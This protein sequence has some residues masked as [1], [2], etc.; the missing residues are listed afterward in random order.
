MP[1][2]HDT[3]CPLVSSCGDHRS[4]RR[5]VHRPFLVGRPACRCT[6]C[7]GAAA[8]GA[9]SAGPGRRGGRWPGSGGASGP[10]RQC[11]RPARP[12]RERPRPAGSLGGRPA[13]A[14]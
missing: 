10:A 1:H 9:G 5:P 12:D 3:F 2:A 8:A 6:G 14:A 13:A 11:P 4:R 7:D